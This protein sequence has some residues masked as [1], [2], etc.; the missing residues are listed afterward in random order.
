MSKNYH[1]AA[2]YFIGLILFFLCRRMG[3]NEAETLH[4]I[5]VGKLERVL[6]LKYNI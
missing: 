6:H 1:V 3:M 4:H 2:L 5:T